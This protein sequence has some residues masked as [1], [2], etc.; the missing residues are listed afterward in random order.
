[1][2]SNAPRAPAK[3]GE[4][5]RPATSA[6]DSNSDLITR[7]EELRSKLSKSEKRIVQFLL[8]DTHSFSRLNVKEV[9]AAADVSEPTVVRFCRRVG[10]KGF[11][12][13]KIQIVQDLAY[14]QAT[15]EGEA[16]R[17]RDSKVM[18]RAGSAPNVADTV[19]DAAATALQRVHAAVN[20]DSVDLA[21]L[22]IAQARRVVIYGLGGSSAVM[23]N[24]THN[25]LF[26]LNISS[27]PHTDSYMQRMSAATLGDKD[28]ALFIS[29]TG[30]PRT[31]L[32][33]LELAKY[34]GA[35]C[36]GITPKDSA[37]G[38]DLDICIDVELTQGGVHQFHPNPMRYAQ[39]YVIDCIAYAV[40][41]HLGDAAETA[42]KRTRAS[43]S[44]LHGIAPLQP[45]GD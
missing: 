4:S 23:A 45:I 14:R 42:L 43:V 5:N 11:K 28:V 30:R 38:R 39:L 33:S 16:G 10:C 19:H 12:D 40:A 18:L 22:A 37:I 1:M 21:A 27:I 32:D 41:L 24:E 29:S 15:Q 20:W 9:A 26:R 3:Q 7:I 44:S 25:R 34:Y 8:H 2:D 31:L 36:I 6:P 35:K 17:A 13:L